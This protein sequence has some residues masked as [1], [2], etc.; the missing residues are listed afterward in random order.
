MKYLPIQQSH[1]NAVEKYS[2]FSASMND[3]K[4]S[5]NKYYAV[6]KCYKEAIFHSLFIK[7][8]QDGIYIDWYK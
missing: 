3:H 7:Y 8:L 5:F 2:Y 4:K 1:L 6:D